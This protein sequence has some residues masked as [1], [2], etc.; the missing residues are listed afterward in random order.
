LILGDSSLRESIEGSV[1]LNSL[2]SSWET[3]LSKHL[4][5]RESFLLY[6]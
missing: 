1:E 2:Q 3:E 4:E 6:R 5:W